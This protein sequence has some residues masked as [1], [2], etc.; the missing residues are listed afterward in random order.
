LWGDLDF[1]N[2]TNTLSI[3]DWSIIGTKNFCA[4][5]MLWI[6]DDFAIRRRKCRHGLT[7]SA[8][9]QYLAQQN[10]SARA[11]ISTSPHGIPN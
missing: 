8:H 7:F 4:M 1:R 3:L 5:V 11:A 2:R 6:A 10:L 9:S